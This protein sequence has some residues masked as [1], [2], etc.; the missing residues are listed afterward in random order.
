MAERKTLFALNL[1]FL[2]KKKGWNQSEIESR[3]G[4]K[5]RT[6]SNW[7]NDV[8][9]PSITNLISISHLFGVTINDLLEKDLYE[10]IQVNSKI[11]YIKNEEKYTAKNTGI[12]TGNYV[13]EDQAKLVKKQIDLLIL[14]QLNTLTNEVKLMR[15]K[16]DK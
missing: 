8:S 6:W 13:N 16:L 7:E 15:E 10:E 3:C 12:D 2:R 5:Q 4:F 9:E 14:E 1:I 11:G